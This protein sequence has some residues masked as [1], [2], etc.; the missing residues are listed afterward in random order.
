L[1]KT[2]FLPSHHLCFWKQFHS[3][4]D[5]HK[6]GRKKK[7]GFKCALYLPFTFYNKQQQNSSFIKNVG[8][9]KNRFSFEPNLFFFLF[10][11][12][13]RWWKVEEFFLCGFIIFLASDLFQFCGFKMNFFFQKLLKQLD[14]SFLSTKGWSRDGDNSKQCFGRM[15]QKFAFELFY[16]SLILWLFDS[17]MLCLFLHF[18]VGIISQHNTTAQHNENCC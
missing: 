9:H 10:R 7:R 17:L 11:C 18:Y 6:S 14:D 8:R 15:N 4:P 12:N 5:S 3:N 16:V 2:H 13:F 1:P